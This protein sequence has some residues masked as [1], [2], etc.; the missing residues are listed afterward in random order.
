MVVFDFAEL[1][2]GIFTRKDGS[3]VTLMLNRHG[4]VVNFVDLIIESY[5]ITV[6]EFEKILEARETG[7]L[8]IKS[9]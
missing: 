5:G 7:R 4:T 9:E 1:N 6:E 8:L 3:K 2:K